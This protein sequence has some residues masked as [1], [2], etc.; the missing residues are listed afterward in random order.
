LHAKNRQPLIIALKGRYCLRHF[1]HLVRQ[2]IF[3]VITCRYGCK[4]SRL[5][6]INDKAY[7][8]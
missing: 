8:F 1:C 6:G 5:T 7:D 3:R 2:A 4:N